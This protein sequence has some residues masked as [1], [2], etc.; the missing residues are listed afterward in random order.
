METLSFDNYE[1][2]AVHAICEY[3]NIKDSY[4]DVSIYCKYDD[5]KTIL[6]ELIS[7]GFEPNSISLSPKYEYDK[8]YCISIYE[9]SIWCSEMYE[10]EYGYIKDEVN[11]AFVFDN[12]NSAML[13]S[14]SA[15]EMYSVNIGSEDEFD[16]CRCNGDCVCCYHNEE[17]Q[18]S[19]D[20]VPDDVDVDGFTMSYQ[21]GDMCVTKS[22]YSS[23]KNL[24][25]KMMEL[26][27]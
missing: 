5:A 20:E 15:E 26:W 27:K 10:D 11:I 4:K 12:C 21:D 23:N 22:F 24:I 25:A 17:I 18:E 7:C 14:I 16:E 1:D 8:E 9:D 19:D 13:K 2:I 3:E 6:M